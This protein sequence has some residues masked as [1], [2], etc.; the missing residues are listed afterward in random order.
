[1]VSAI[2]WYRSTPSSNSPT[3][4]SMLQSPCPLV[5]AAIDAR[6]SGGGRTMN[7]YFQFQRA[8]LVGL[9]MVVAIGNATTTIAQSVTPEETVRSVRKML[10][11][12]PYYGV[13][14]YIVFRVDRSTV[15]LSGY[16]FDGRLKAD[17]EMAVKR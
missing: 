9:A 17:A 1:M 10:E 11:R 14:D 6:R 7:A 15:Y 4:T 16:S 5:R 8:A 2:P 3:H 12:L 13:F